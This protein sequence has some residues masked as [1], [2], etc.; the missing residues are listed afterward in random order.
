MTRGICQASCAF[1][2]QSTGEESC[3]LSRIRWNI[4]DFED[5][6][7]LLHDQNRVCIQCLNYPEVFE[8]LY[9]MVKRIKCPV[10]VSAQPF[11]IDEMRAL[12][13]HVDRLSISLDCFTKELFEKYKPFYNWDLHWVRMRKAVEI[14]GEGNVI[15]HMI[16][17]LGETE[18]EAVVTLDELIRTGVRPS[19]FALTPLKGTA[20][21]GMPAPDLGTYRRLQMARYL[22][23]ERCIDK[24]DIRYDEDD[25]ISSF[26]I[27]V[28]KTVDPEAFMTQGCPN[29]NRPFFN[30]KPGRTPYNFPCD[31]SESE[32]MAIIKHANVD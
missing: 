14:F 6:V 20:L 25:M 2:A 8:D 13:E 29:C 12:S 1:C 10:S 11:T 15:S 18:R 4:W 23:L 19:L 31:I 27:D 3:M 21:E 7:D 32:Y 24:E 30:E 5:I 22:L 26:G 9:E 16:V 17:G 28:S